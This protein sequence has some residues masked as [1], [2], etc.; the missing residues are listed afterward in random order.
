[1]A[2]ALYQSK[3][4]GSVFFVIL[5]SHLKNKNKFFNYRLVLEKCSFWLVSW[6]FFPS[7]FWRPQIHKL[8]QTPLSFH[9]LSRPWK[10]YPIFPKLS[11]T[12]KDCANP[13]R[14]T[15]SVRNLILKEQRQTSFTVT[16]DWSP[17]IQKLKT[18]TSPEADNIPTDHPQT[19]KGH[20]L[21]SRSR[22]YSHWS[23]SNQKHRHPLSHRSRQQKSTLTQKPTTKRR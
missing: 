17:S 15:Q 13:V 18:S 11:K 21:S 14:L 1:M 9:R 23:P 2:N 10:A 7:F 4:I 8:P 3:L 20:L 5:H 12:F 16:H 6:Q 22:K 19:Q